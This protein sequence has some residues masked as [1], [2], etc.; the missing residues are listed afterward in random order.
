MEVCKLGAG[1]GRAG[2]S[3]MTKGLRTLLSSLGYILHGK[4][5]TLRV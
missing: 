4:E 5:S 2:G 3:L 1:A